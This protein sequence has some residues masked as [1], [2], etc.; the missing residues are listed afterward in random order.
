MNWINLQRE[1]DCSEWKGSGIISKEAVSSNNPPIEKEDVFLTLKTK[2]VALEK[3]LTQ[4]DNFAKFHSARV[5]EI[6]WIVADMQN[7]YTIIK[8]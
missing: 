1:D 5:R 8:K 3:A 4:E 2:L 6:I 7:N